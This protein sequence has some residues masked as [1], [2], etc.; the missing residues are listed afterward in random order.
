MRLRNM[1]QI[2][3]RAAKGSDGQDRAE[4]CRRWSGLYAEDLLH[5]VLNIPV[6]GINNGA[7]SLDSANTRALF[8]P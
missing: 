7:S 4:R 3:W 1:S 6:S 5:L 2:A 8:S